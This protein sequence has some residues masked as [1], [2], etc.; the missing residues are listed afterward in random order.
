MKQ[1]LPFLLGFVAVSFLR[2]AEPAQLELARQVTQASQISR[3]FD[4]MG[5]Q[6]EMM[7]SQSLNLNNPNLSEEQKTRATETMGRIKTLADESIKGL[8]EQLDAIYAETFSEGELKAMLAFFNSPEG[9]SMLAK[10]PLIMQ[11]LMPLARAMQQ[12]LMPK[13]D[14]IIKA[15]KAVESV[16]NPAGAF[17]P[18]VV[19]LTEAQPA[20]PAPAPA[21]TK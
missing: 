1:I 9:Q 8:M 14:A 10:Q 19:P 13:I 17:P 4:Q 21:T 18:P 12:D 20:T 5:T 2:A 6:I 3:I 15:A 11:R 16:K 7:T